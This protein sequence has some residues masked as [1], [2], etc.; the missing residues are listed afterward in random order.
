MATRGADSVQHAVSL[1][2]TGVV[3]GVGYRPFVYTLARRLGVT[4]WVRNASDGVWCIA[5]ASPDVLAAFERGLRDEAPPMAVVESVTALAAI[6]EGFSDFT[7][8]ASHA[9][10][11]AMTLVSPDIATCESC[12]GELLDPAD[13][14]YRYPFI[15]CTNCGPRFTIIEDVPYDR[16]KTTMRDF[17]MCVECAA[18]YGDP[19]DRRFHA[20]PD[21]CFVCGPRLY[22]NGAGLANNADWGW[23]P[24]SDAVPRPHR[25]R[26]LERLRSDA[27]LAAAA[28]VLRDGGI[29]A[30]KGLGGFQLACDATNEA[31]VSRLRDRKRRWGKPFAVMMPSLVAAREY[32]EISDA[33]AALLQ[34]PP[35]PIVLLR[36][37]GEGVGEG[38]ARVP[39]PAEDSGLFADARRGLLERATLS[40]ALAPGLK[41][42]GV[43]LP[44]TPLHHILLG[45]LG[46]PL[47]MTSG[48]LSDEPIATGNIEAL[49]R[50]STIADAVLLH[51]REICSRY[52]DSVTR[53]GACGT[54][55]LRRARGY[56][57][58]PVRLPFSSD[59]AILAV[60]PEQKNTVTL[61][62]GEYA[63][64]SQ[65]IGDMENAETFDAFERTIELYERLFRISPQVVAYDLHPEYLATKH[66]LTL[67]LPG[68][69]VQH[70]HAHVAGVAAEHGIDGP[71]IGV[72]LD[73]TGYGPDGTIW[74]GEVL[75]ATLA[76]FER[77]AH[78]ATMPMPGGAAAIRRPAR[79]AI[80]TLA[81]FGLLD[82][83]GA[84][85]LRSRLAEAEEE[86]LLR[87]IERGVNSPLTSSMGRLFDA[88]AAIC[89]VRDDARYEGQA[90]IEL[91]ALADPAEGGSYAFRLL[92]GETS[93]IDS[94]PVL[95]AVLDDIAHGVAAPVIS[96]RFHRG[97]AAAIV[98][99]CVRASVATGTRTVALS[100]G[101]FM[102]RLVADRVRLGLTEAGL[103]P[104]THIKL[105]VNDGGVSFGQAVVAWARRHEL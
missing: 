21:A 56:A 38:R 25:D 2:V 7:I 49:E 94:A 69:G 19:A 1:H 40:D 99:E 82:H 98:G 41:E 5:E 80:G 88:V 93:V 54:E 74:G 66:A 6:P 31:A 92:D 81:G 95:E 104:I 42:L 53:A 76:G 102:N 71:F 70:H 13:R 22:L 12:A 34:S 20:Q 72:A 33:E 100:G 67:G 16:P 3:Q 103:Q 43:M 91:E 89:G 79:M 51:D 61:L 62:T 64:V 28:Q 55:F 30:L 27:I 26:E 105:P 84:A 78:L 17:P 24:N 83:P 10:E 73:G 68:I 90:A 11:G 18:E 77:V 46:I 50:L 45:D 87:M 75:L 85:P 65:H 23:T 4:G 35:A 52:D 48:N 36:L 86:T 44:Y 37:R 60:G 9:E 59:V 39:Q 15:N 97:V 101:V 63:F 8:V 29:L 14:R 57:P 32:C 47:V 96:A 58:F